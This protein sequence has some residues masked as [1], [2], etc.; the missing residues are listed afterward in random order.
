MLK[1]NDR[2]VTQLRDSLSIT[3]AFF[4][5]PSL[6]YGEQIASEDDYEIW[7][8][9]TIDDDGAPLILTRWSQIDWNE[10]D[11]DSVTAT[12]T[13]LARFVRRGFVVTPAEGRDPARFSHSLNSSGHAMWRDLPPE[14]YQHWVVENTTLVSLLDEIFGEDL[15]QVSSMA[16]KRYTGVDLGWHRDYP[17]GIDDPRHSPLGVQVNIALDA[18]T[19]Q[20]G[21]TE[22]IE[23]SHINA[24]WT[25]GGRLRQ[26]TGPAG[27]MFIYHAATWHR[28]GQSWEDTP[29]RNLL[30]LNFV[31]KTTPR[32]DYVAIS[33]LVTDDEQM[34]QN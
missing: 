3:D 29:M 8:A 30:L 7:K 4:A 33:E 25:S 23:N 9:T 17:Y 13:M 32:K 14:W 10:P 31:A 5:A 26:F 16:A 12:S 34:D 22:F 24:Q 2:F 27:T 15:W 6:L 1:I 21:A 19:A 28:V 18:Q 20:N 11:I